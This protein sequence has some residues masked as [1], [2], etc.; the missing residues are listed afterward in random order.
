MDE[1]VKPQKNSNGALMIAG[2]FAI[3]AVVLGVCL[4]I[5]MMKK[6]DA[7]ECKKVADA[8][9]KDDKTEK[10]LKIV[11]DVAKAHSDAMGGYNAVKTYTNND[12]DGVVF[13]IGDGVYMP[14]NLSYGLDAPSY[15]DS[16]DKLLESKRVALLNKVSDALSSN[17]LKKVS[18]PSGYFAWGGD[19]SQYSFYEGDGI[20]CYANTVYGFSFSCADKTWYSEDDKSLTLALAEAYK[21][22]EGRDVGY[23]YAKKSDIKKNS[24]GTYERI[25][26]SFDDAAAYFYRKVGG[27]WKFFMGAQQAADCSLYN[28]SELKE[29]YSGEK[30]WDGTVETVVKK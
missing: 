17:G 24:D 5:A 8:E 18:A 27:E 30:C 23:L 12:Y 1:S 22:K 28:T 14:T 11:D 2:I 29:A 7:A 13:S 26:G 15:N 19:S 20:I 16:Y 10:I 4:V 9:K 25:M 3:I 6:C 21:K